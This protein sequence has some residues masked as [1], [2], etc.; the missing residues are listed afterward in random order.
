M[1]AP[2]EF[3][4]SLS[5]PATNPGLPQTAAPTASRKRKRAAPATAPSDSPAP[6]DLGTTTECAFFHFIFQFEPQK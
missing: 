2:P 6:S 3:D 1:H 5:I 4:P